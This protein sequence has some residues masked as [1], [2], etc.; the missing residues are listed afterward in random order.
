[1]DLDEL[2]RAV[3]IFNK[4]VKNMPKNE[5]CEKDINISKEAL[6]ALRKISVEF[7]VNNK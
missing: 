1:M 3:E 2:T 7:S 5:Y 4:F 6:K